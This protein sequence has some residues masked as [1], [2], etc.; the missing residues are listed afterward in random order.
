MK[1]ETRTPGFKRTIIFVCSM[2]IALFALAQTEVEET[3]KFEA[4]IDPNGKLAFTN[5]SFDTEIK[6]WD[7]NYVELQM[8]VRLKG[9][10]DDI[11]E[12]LEA[13]HELCFEGSTGSRRI[14]TVFWESINSTGNRHKI[15]LSNGSKVTLK[16]FSVD[17]V[18]FIP[19]TISIDIDNKYSDINM[20]SIS[21][22]AEIKLYSGK[23]YAGTF[24]GKTTL[25]LRY[26][27][28]FIDNIPEAGMDIYDSDIEL[29][30][31]GNFTIKSKYSKVEI[32]RAGD[33]LFDSY[34]DNFA[35]GELGRFDGS[36]K[37]SD[38]VLG[39]ASVIIFDFYDSNLECQVTGDINGRSKYSEIGVKE[40]LSVTLAHSY[41]DSF[42]LG[43]VASLSCPDS[44]YTDYNIR[45][46]KGNFSLNG[47]DDNVT[48]YALEPDFKQITLEGK[49][50]D[51]NFS[52]LEPAA[53][54]LLVDMKYGRVDYPEGEFERK[55]YIRD[56]NQLTIEATTR[57]SG[58][59]AASRFSVK[60]YDNKAR[61]AHV[62]K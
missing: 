49:Y 47:Y 42:E 52:I 8:N 11:K 34:D 24:G 22:E 55:T 33:M 56:N 20:E 30:T 2:L 27:K 4:D 62:S 58:S 36:A 35:I 44:K 21:G 17:N 51:F 15:R 40:A 39:P 6:T 29:G 5:R 59:G 37:Y 57:N 25:D 48:V 18:L 10:E 1:N 43:S 12:T 45:H 14:N 19:K 41:D 13:I 3:V 38:F 61:I 31:C 7:N 54:S 46:L 60:G 50:G 28:A 16:K 26:S 53:Y 32:Q 23:I 9:D